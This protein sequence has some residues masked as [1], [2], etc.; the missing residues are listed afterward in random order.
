MTE[1][2]LHRLSPEQ[3]LE[4]ERAA[5]Y[6]SEYYDGEMSA[7]AGA[8]PEHV[9][10]AT[11]IASELR[12]RLKSKPCRSFSNDL[13]LRVSPTGLYTYPD[14]TVVCGDLQF[15]D[16]SRDTV[17]NP[18][19]IVEVLSDSTEASDRG[20]KFEHYR[21]LESL[22]EYILVAQDRALVEQYARDGNGRWVLTEVNGL[23]A[24]IDLPSIECRLSLADVYDKVE[25]PA[26]RA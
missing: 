4:I 10:I 16:D 15:A 12:N 5:E 8:S 3:Y 6:K 14:V 24:V 26:T 7:M 20:K 21:T 1:Q 19:V 23:D 17:V 2:P 9:L 22:R 11:N 18:T 13:R 25:F